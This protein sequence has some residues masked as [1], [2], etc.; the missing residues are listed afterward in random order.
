[1]LQVPQSNSCIPIEPVQTNAFRCCFSCIIAT[2]A[3]A[4]GF[5]Q[6]CGVS[7]SAATFHCL[8]C[9]HIICQLHMKAVNH[10]KIRLQKLQK[11]SH[12]NQSLAQAEYHRAGTTNDWKLFIYMDNWHIFGSFICLFIWKAGFRNSNV[13]PS[14]C[15][16]R[17]NSLL[18]CESKAAYIL[19]FPR[20]HSGRSLLHWV[21]LF[22]LCLFI[23]C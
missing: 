10:R 19:C 20:S 23:Y 13:A 15:L 5:M 16:N 18:A 2:S 6:H 21:V 12:P 7:T 1:M 14:A 11:H 3:S 8:R 17:K 4:P 9:H 22:V